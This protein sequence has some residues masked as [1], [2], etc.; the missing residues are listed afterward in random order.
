[1]VKPRGH[2]NAKRLQLIRFNYCYCNYYFIFGRLQKKKPQTASRI[3]LY[4]I[5]DV[6]AGVFGVFVFYVIESSTPSTLQNEIADG[7][8]QSA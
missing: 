3:L 5:I 4:V 2:G 8:H 6:G 7:Y 1:M